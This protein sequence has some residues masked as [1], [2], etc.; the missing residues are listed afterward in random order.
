MKK[1]LLSVSKH[2]IIIG[3][4]VIIYYFISP[5]R[6][7]IRE[8]EQPDEIGEQYKH[9]MKS[10]DDYIQFEKRVHERQCYETYSW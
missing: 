8:F 2:L 9:I 3:V 7:C 4:L 10:L 1:L 6:T 5:Y